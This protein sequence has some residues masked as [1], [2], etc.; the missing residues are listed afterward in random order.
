MDDLLADFVAETREMLQAIEGEIVAWEADPADRERLDAIFRFV[1]TVKG[2]CGFFDFPRLERLSHG[3]ESALSEVRAGRRHASTGLVT[4]VLA[5][6]DRITDMIDAIDAGES[7]PEGG[8]EM[9]IAALEPRRDE[10]DSETIQA[11][12]Q[13]GP[14]AARTNGNTR[15]I[16]L[17]VELL[18][19]VMSGVSDM[20]LARN[21]L[22]RR[23]REQGA[24]PALQGPFERLSAILDEVREGATRMR[25]QRLEHLFGALPRMVR[26]LSSELGKQVMI[27]L[28]G[29][30]V[31][32]DREMIESVRDPLMHIL[33][34]AIDHGIEPPAQRLAAG[35]REIGIV[36]VS[37]RR[38]GNRIV[39]GVSDDG[40]GIALDRLAEKAV[41]AG[42]ASAA[43][44][45]AMTAEQKLDLIFAPGLST[46]DTVSQVSGRGVG[47]DVVR[48]N[49]ERFGGSV[50]VSSKEGRG[51]IVFLHLPLTLSI[52]EGLTVKVGSH[53]LGLPRSYI[54]EIARSVSRSV[55][56]DRLGDGIFLTFRGERVPCLDLAEVLGLDQEVDLDRATFVFLR[57]VSG[58]LFALAVDRV[59]DNEDFVLKP[60]PPALEAIGL[61]G[62]TVLLDDGK[63]ILKIDIPGLAEAHGLASQTRVRT[64]SADG[65]TQEAVASPQH[66]VVFTSLTGRRRALRMA[67]IRHI[68]MLP[69]SAIEHAGDGMLATVDGTI[70]PLLGAEG[71]NIATETITALRL[72]DGESTLLYAVGGVVDSLELPDTIVPVEGDDTLEGT[73]L[74]DGAMVGVVDAHRLFARH[75]RRAAPAQQ[76]T[77]RLPTTDPWVVSFLEPLIRSAGYEILGE[78]DRRAAD[79]SVTLD[80]AREPDGDGTVVRLRSRPE[81]S[82]GDPH[83]IYRYDREALLTALASARSGTR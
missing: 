4:A 43:E 34:N 46:A 33:R 20:V 35:K 16:R 69:V 63:P 56:V 18:D 66:A 36:T 55:E 77:C 52:V 83:S 17:P 39:I 24:D 42:V 22:A 26:D 81:G 7:L 1:H 31:E 14:R 5:I 53:T 62:G 38:T 78:D 28:E 64:V 61:Y 67:V 8:D 32:L 58:D 80:A 30:D 27:D 21:E 9:L 29:G 50:S 59:L 45:A 25:M 65:G 54:V 3:A 6:I 57:L 70:L 68:H 11:G 15:S 48:A 12:E 44:V 72:D 13:A 60:L 19:R 74:I 82:D 76:P 49:V 2:N 79:I 41:A 71:A 75:G 40:R 37:A 47:M 73:A 23:L 51:T 10:P